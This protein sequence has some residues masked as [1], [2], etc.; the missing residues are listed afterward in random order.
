MTTI[1]WKITRPLPPQISA[2]VSRFEDLNTIVIFGDTHMY[3]SQSTYP[4]V[5]T[6]IT[7]NPISFSNNKLVTI[8]ALQVGDYQQVIQYGD[9][10]RSGTNWSTIRNLEFE[11]SPGFISILIEVEPMEPDILA[12]LFRPPPPARGHLK[13]PKMKLHQLK[14]R[15]VAFQIKGIDALTN[16]ID[17]HELRDLDLY[18]CQEGADILRR[19]EN[20]QMMNLERIHIKEELALPHMCK[21]LRQFGPEGSCRNL[22]ILELCCWHV[23]AMPYENHH[24][25]LSMYNSYEDNDEDMWDDDD[26]L[27]ESALSDETS[28]QSQYPPPALVTNRSKYPLPQPFR[29]IR[30]LR[31][32]RKE[33]WG[34]KRLVLD[35]RPGMPAASTRQLPQQEIFFEAFWR[36]KELAIPVSYETN[37]CWVCIAIISWKVW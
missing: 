19:W 15:D 21:F 28:S 24:P 25:S 13:T 34:L 2:S 23:D 3:A 20:N 1:R 6:P 18:Y 8:K 14:L 7:N 22:K 11:V 9:V 4:H 29:S 16:A 5:P 35:M 33:G 31:G 36:L 17:A 37:S 27:S 12:G 30:D 10:I 26:D 32:N